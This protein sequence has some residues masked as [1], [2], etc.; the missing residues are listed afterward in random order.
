M[1]SREPS[2]ALLPAPS[3]RRDATDPRA[4]VVRKGLG[5]FSGYPRPIRDMTKRVRTSSLEVAYED[6]RSPQAEPSIPVHG[7]TDD[8]RTW[9]GVVAPLVGAGHRTLTPYLRG[10][11]PTRFLEKT[12]FRSGQL[13]ALGQ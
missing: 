7:F 9:D 8:I 5:L 1:R 13:A 10:F 4:D 12:T 3:R 11:G 2:P 6:R